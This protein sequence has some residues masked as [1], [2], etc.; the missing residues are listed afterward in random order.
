MKN[1]KQNTPDILLEKYLLGE[2]S[3]KESENL[4]RRLS[5]DK[6]TLKKLNELKKSN[7]EILKKYTPETM[8]KKI[9][10]RYENT[11]DMAE[12]IKQKSFINKIFNIHLTWK[13]LAPAFSLII[14]ALIMIPII[15][16]EISNK[17]TDKKDIIRIKGTSQL[18]IYQKTKNK[19]MK[20]KDNDVVK[21]GD[22]VQLA[23][24]AGNNKY[25]VIFS[26]DGRGVLTLHY[27]YRN[28]TPAKLLTTKKHLLN[29]AY[30]L[31]DAP[32]YER[33]FFIA[34]SEP[35]EVKDLLKKA[36]FL[37]KNPD[38]AILLS[39]KL[40]KKYQIIT[41]TLIKE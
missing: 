2:L 14:L 20:L 24:S 27:P 6:N 11:K 37:K 36:S 34:S 40:F 3:K 16:N 19:E 22:I 9:T 39:K 13:Q 7:Q 29:E 18:F 17:P 41:M 28:S 15:K 26:I 1:N 23:Y 10:Q 4:N 21:Q 5:Q 32:K 30:E 31:D 38:R 25:G 35:I 8:A 33:F 12:R